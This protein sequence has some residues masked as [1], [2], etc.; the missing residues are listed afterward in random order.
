MEPLNKEERTKAFLLFIVIFIVTVGIVISAVFFSI[1][2]PRKENSSLKERNK[3]L[4]A[5]LSGYEQLLIKA[6]AISSKFEELKDE[7]KFNTTEM[8]INSE[9][10]ALKAMNYSGDTDKKLG[11]KMAQVYLGW[12]TD[13]KKAVEA[14]KASSGV[15][16]CKTDLQ[17][18]ETAREGLEDKVFELR[19]ELNRCI[20]SS[21]F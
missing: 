9:I 13:K 11:E 14:A 17:L 6:E 3:V 1:E 20:G 18:C 8:D 4:Q 10:G 7:S 21:N 19:K 16:G 5:S 15:E 12:L 2:V